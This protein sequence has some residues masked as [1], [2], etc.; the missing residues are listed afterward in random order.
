[1]T[2]PQIASEPTTIVQ[3]QGASL[4]EVI[5][6]AAADPQTDVEKMERLMGMYERITARQAES[7]FHAAM[8]EMQPQ[9]PIIEK[10]GAIKNKAGGKQAGYARW[11]DVV[12]GITPV[13]SRHGFS[14]TFRVRN[15]GEKVI[16]TG[17]L[18]HRGGHSERTDAPPLMADMSGSKNSVQ[19][20]GSSVSYGKRYAAFAILNIAARDEDDDG[21]RGGSGSQNITE[22]QF[23]MLRNLMEE[24]QADEPRFLTFLGVEHLEEL[25]ATK[26]S[27]AVAALRRK[28]ADRRA[29]ANA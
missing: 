18:A 29:A 10:A 2:V 4:M 9:L 28:I 27:G 24:A 22:D 17:V 1:M 23:M 25:P 13:I 26:L 14:L 6:R 16:V 19:A 15:E 5:A 21:A 20:L 11:E 12:E 7:D 8:A 3:S